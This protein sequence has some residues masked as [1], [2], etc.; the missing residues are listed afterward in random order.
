MKQKTSAPPKI[1][2]VA[3]WL[4]NMGGA[5]HL[6]YSLHK[7]FPDA[8]IY[9]S[10]YDP[11]RCPQFNSADVHTSYLQRLP[12][13]LRRRHQLFAIF[14]AKAFRRLDVSAYDIVIS[15]ASAEA[16]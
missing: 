15:S 1:A 14:R 9:T 12:A 7:A 3:D 16:K 10:V 6:L 2:L 8:P 13:F 11:V 5:E 4:T